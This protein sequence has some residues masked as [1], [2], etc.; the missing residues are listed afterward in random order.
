MS[1]WQAQTFNIFP[2]LLSRTSPLTMYVQSN[3][4]SSNCIKNIYKNSI[5][6]NMWIKTNSSKYKLKFAVQ[7]VHILWGQSASQNIIE[8]VFNN[9]I[10]YVAS[11]TIVSHITREKETEQ[12][13]I[14]NPLILQAEKW[15]IKRIRRYNLLQK[16]GFKGVNF[17]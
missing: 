7:L 12:K 3:D 11:S 9:Q 16:E 14:F 6:K 15:T 2:L 10:K 8:T 1:T 17:K 13:E 5:Y 4:Q